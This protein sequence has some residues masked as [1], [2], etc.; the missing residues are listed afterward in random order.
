MEALFCDNHAK[1]ELKAS[2]LIFAILDVHR[3]ADKTELRL[4]REHG[5]FAAEILLVR[6]QKLL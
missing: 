1:I 6:Y 3:Q 5:E 2:T 4:E